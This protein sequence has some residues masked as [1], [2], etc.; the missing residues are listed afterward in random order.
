[1]LGAAGVAAAQPVAVLIVNQDYR[2][3]GPIGGPDPLPGLEAAFEE[4]GFKVISERDATTGEVLAAIRF[5]RAE[6]G[7]A[8]AAVFYYAGYVRQLNGRNFLIPVNADPRTAF[9]ML[10]Q[11]IDVTS[12]RA[13]M[14]DA[15]GRLSIAIVDG[16]YPDPTLD[17]IEGLGP[18][19]AALT[20]DAGE[21]IVLGAQPGRILSPEARPSTVA[22]AVRRAI[23]QPTAPLTAIFARIVSESGRMPARAG[24]VQVATGTAMPDTLL[25]AAAPA[26]EP[27]APEPEP[28]PD[29]GSSPVRKPAP[30]TSETTTADPAPAEPPPA[31]PELAM[32]GPAFEATLDEGELKLVQIAL[33]NIGLYRGPIDAVFGSGTR[34]AI[35]IFQ[36]S[37][38]EDP[39]GYLTKAQMNALL[40]VG[41]V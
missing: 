23:S 24:A 22:D 15:G 10:T 34:E 40:E 8:E 19:L 39:T 21:A 3:L 35:L 41:G 6:G 17:A 16:A 28:E 20:P 38:G 14:A 7:S 5:M 32:D 9:D 36:R 31:D 26:A 33:R 30:T 37:R 4:A 29:P 12:V 2:K 25:P 11:G 13:A 18:G 27:P 1:M